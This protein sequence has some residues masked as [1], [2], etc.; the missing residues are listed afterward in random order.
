MQQAAEEQGV[1]VS[2]NDQRPLR[3]SD[4]WHLRRRHDQRPGPPNL[5][6]PTDRSHP[7]A[8]FLARNAMDQRLFEPISASFP[9]LS[10]FFQVRNDRGQISLPNEELILNNDTWDYTMNAALN[11][12]LKLGSATFAFNT[13]LQFTVRRDTE[14]PVELNQNLFRQFAYMSTNALGNWLTVQGEG[15]P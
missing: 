7:A 8:D 10:G 2:R 14:S 5:P 11:P 9:A 6:Q 3:R 12:V 4:A 1:Q 13:G 15:L